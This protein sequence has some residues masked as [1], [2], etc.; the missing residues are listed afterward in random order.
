MKNWM[1]A[2]CGD[3]LTY[4]FMTTPQKG[5]RMNPNFLT[6][7]LLPTFLSWAVTPTLTLSELTTIT[8]YY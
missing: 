6:H 5:E 3:A 1:T 2:V 7:T 8:Y 4:Y